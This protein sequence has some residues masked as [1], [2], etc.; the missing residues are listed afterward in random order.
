MDLAT[1]LLE[2]YRANRRDLPFRRTRDP[3]AILVAEVML[4]RTRV[5]AGVPYFE[6]FLAAFPTVVDLAKASEEEVL[7][8]WEGLGFYGRARNLHRAASAIVERYGGRVPS[9]FA[10]LREF[11]GIGDYT[12]GA[13]A[14]IGFGEQVPAI[15]GN[16]VRVLARVFRLRGDLT[17]SGAKRRLQ[18]IAASLVPSDEPG[19]YNQ[20]LMELG[21][22]ICIPRAP[23]CSLCPIRSMCGA[24]A[25]GRPAAYPEPRRVA[26]TPTVRV[27][28]VLVERDRKVLLHKRPAKGLLAGFWGL[29]GGEIADAIDEAEAL[30]TAL[31]SMG[32]HVRV[33]EPVARADHTFSHRR[34]EGQVHR[35]R[36]VGRPSLPPEFR[37]ASLE[38]LRD[39]PVVSFHRRILERVALPPRRQAR[40]V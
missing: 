18:G 36:L 27:A 15:D 37:W 17:R 21:A 34:W 16:A 24:Y 14:S 32:F 39:L 29:P 3:Y 22:T 19:S 40:L 5:V 25:E 23:R 12:A 31:R 9:R 11:P 8:A 26:V 33:R 10:D 35:G 13:V 7:K 2:W 1:P 6:R 20:A 30:R 4:Q 28:F 38:E